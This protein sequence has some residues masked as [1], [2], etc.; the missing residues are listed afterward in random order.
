MRILL[1]REVDIRKAVSRGISGG[2]QQLG[3]AMVK[4]RAV[5]IGVEVLKA[6]NVVKRSW[7]DERFLERR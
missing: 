3:L 7:R 4:L 2:L 5:K 1:W 6:V